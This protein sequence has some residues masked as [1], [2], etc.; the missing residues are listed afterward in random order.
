MH[1]DQQDFAHWQAIYKDPITNKVTAVHQKDFFSEDIPEADKV[2]YDNLDRGDNL[3]QFQMLKPSGDVVFSVPFKP[4]Q[5]DRLIW[6]RRRQLVAGE[7]EQWF[8]IVGKRGA[9]VA[10][11]LPDYS[12]ILDDNFSEDNALLGDIQP[13][14]GEASD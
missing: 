13:V 4:G 8:Y 1:D 10:C 6:R 7:G 3:I 11:M 14:N 5:G 9:F 12:I 2:S